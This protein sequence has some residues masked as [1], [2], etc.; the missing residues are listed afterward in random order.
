MREILFRG[1]YPDEN[2]ESTAFVNGEWIKGHWVYGFYVHYDDILDNNRDDCD[3]IVE[4][5][6]GKDFIF[7]KVIPETVCQYTGLTDKNVTKIFDGDIVDLSNC[8]NLPF[9]YDRIGK[10]SVVEWKKYYAGFY[11][12]CN[13]DSD[14]GTSVCS[15]QVEVIG[16]IYEN[17]DLVKFVEAL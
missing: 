14:C 10:I 11:P 6:N 12:F 1:F 4:R 17:P 15:E 2:G 16:N 7:K 5:H 3:Y 8:T 13:Y 9:I